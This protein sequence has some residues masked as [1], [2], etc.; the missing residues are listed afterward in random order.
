MSQD[1]FDWERLE[2]RFDSLCYFV[3]G[4]TRFETRDEAVERLRA[5]KRR[6]RGKREEPIQIEPGLIP[7]VSGVDQAAVEERRAIAR[8]L[9]DSIR[10]A[11]TTRSTTPKFINEWG[12]FSSAAGTI[13]FLFFLHSKADRE[14]I[15]RS[16]GDGAA[17]SA[18]IRKR[19]YSKIFVRY[20]DKRAG[21]HRTEHKVERFC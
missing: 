17:R 5:S 7:F 21:R 3:T 13:E 12:R 4:E 19:W 6:G 15:A 1:D 20:W 8:D 14:I 16:G 9:M 2:Q 10:A 11:I 18:R